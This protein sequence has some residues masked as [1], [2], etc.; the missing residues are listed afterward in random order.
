MMNGTHEF[1]RPSG[2]ATTD[3]FAMQAH[4]NY[5]WV[6]PGGK[7]SSWGSMWKSGLVY[8]LDDGNWRAF[9]RW[10]TQGMDH[11]LDLLCIAVDPNDPTRFFTGSWGAGLIEMKDGVVT[12]YLR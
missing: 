10:N 5:L 6:V 3:V 1:I 9:N 7:T 8:G 12:R 11:L 2:P 4:Q